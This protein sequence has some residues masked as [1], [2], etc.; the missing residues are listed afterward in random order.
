MCK[1][2]FL[3]LVVF[4]FSLFVQA[5]Q[6]KS[7]FSIVENNKS[8]CILTDE[9]DF[10]VVQIA[11]GIF[12]HDV[13]QISGRKVV[14]AAVKNQKSDITII[15]G[16]IGKNS[17]ID[18][19]IANKKLDVSE[20]KGQWERF[21]IQV[22]QNPMK[23]LKKALV[24]VGSD[25]RGTAYGILELSRMMG[26]SP[27]EW[28]ADVSPEKKSEIVI[29]VEN[30]V[31][32]SPSVKYRGVF[33]NDE[34]WGLQR[35]AALNFEP[36]TGDIGP[37][38][39][40]KVFELLLRLRANTIWPAM[41]SST[42]PFYSYPQNK[43]VADDYAIVIGTSHAEPMLSN[44][45]TEWNHKTMGEYRYDTN[46]TVIKNLF[47][48]RVKETAKFENIYTTGMRG[49]H[50]SPMI[51]GEDDTDQQV[52]LLENIITDQR[53]ILKKEIKKEPNTI[54]QAF[55]P[56]KEVLDYY[57]KGLQLPEDIT[58]VWT[59][60]NYGYMR[61]LSNP[62]EQTR[63]GG[64]GVYYHTSYWG[65]PHDYL[66][67]NSTNPVLMWEEMSKAYE[68]QSRDLWI[69]NCGD[70]KPHEY[71][72]ELFLDMAWNMDAF[73]K[74]TSVKN[75]MNAWAA[76]EFGNENATAVTDI[77]F[78][79]NRL[80]FIRRPEF[81]AWSQV[82]PVTKSGVTELNQFHYGDEVST[83]INDYQAIENT[84]E[85]LY[86]DIPAFRKDAFYQ[87]VYYPVIAASKINQKW[88][89]SFKNDFDAKQNKRSANDDGEQAI[90]AYERIVKETQHYNETV[91]KGK[92]N[93]IMT[94]EPRFLPAFS[95][96]SFVVVH[97]KE[98]ASLGLALE[99]Y[100]MEVNH[101]IV[102][103][104]ADVL[105][106]FNRYTDNHYFIDVYLKGEESISWKAVPKAD[107]IRISEA[108]GTLSASSGNQKKRLWVSI[109]WEK[110][111]QGENKKEAPLGHD[112]QLI[113]PS[114]KV[115]NAIDF[116]T[117][118]GTIT[119]GVSVYNPKFEALENYSGFIEDKGF[120]S[121]NAENFTRNQ[122]GKEAKWET[123]EG[124]GYSGKVIAAL[125][126]SAGP[127]TDLKT[128]QQNS[129]VVEY[130]FYS[131][132]FGEADVRIQ[133]VPTHADYNGRGV[134]CAIAIDNAE[135]VIVNF[136]TFGRSD[137]WMQN[138][139]KNAS[140]QSAKQII[141]KA[142]K[143]TLKIWM[144]DSGVMLDQILI[145][146]G[147]WKNSY[148]FPRETFKK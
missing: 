49:E 132:N 108:Q 71:N 21:S 116:V 146:L 8:T 145:D 55:V 48:K 46:S 133:A 47:S 144:V 105:P 4:Q 91:S 103:C 40:A 97:P 51:V 26:I 2:T 113:P 32:K 122:S 80:A 45:N 62:K 50:D 36:E 140:V 96:P 65:R 56:Y 126:R 58:L 79:N 98:K 33:L 63:S 147:G 89:Y 73:E 100:E 84:V 123:F 25:R 138:V 99:G 130:D 14:T 38:T 102:N 120:V 41:H 29:S 135:P 82:E 23:G 101:E 83:R 76:R 59:D 6:P 28:W 18:A 86:A 1:H 117:K 112:F 72:I 11:A 78:E 17:T 107:W 66:W 43:V 134:R 27:W 30:K 148:A 94:M 68:F 12:A 3:F 70:I 142:G 53:A 5:Q 115:N 22:V 129:P 90:K 10:K 92:W 143:H 106:V 24:V 15:A 137:Q 128:I 61:Q 110:V 109:D 139:L 77:L 35:W 114:Y 104:F 81:M 121:I 9:K 7:E 67:L 44:I 74:S 119:I 39:Y 20:F 85:K 60:D 37:K 127:E 111:P 136:Q 88:L 34:D 64:A 125:P 52:K 141:N 54:P 87:L 131:F 57:Q 95:K 69:L 19:M 31:S 75:H 124:L 16:T 93:H 118:D 42:K 13:F